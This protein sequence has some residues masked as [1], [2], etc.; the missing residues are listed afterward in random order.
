MT[1]Y[2][3]SAIRSDRPGMECPVLIVDDQIMVAEGLQR[4]LE[5]HFPG[6]KIVQSGEELLK[7]VAT[8][9]PD[10][11][12][13]DIGMPVL[14]GIEVTRFLRTISPG[15]KVIILTEHNRP[16]YAAGAVRAG[17]SGYVLKSCTF[18]ELMIAIRRVLKGDMYLTP[19]LRE[20]AGPAALNLRGHSVDNTLTSRQREV[21]VFVAEG[22]TAKEIANRLNFSVKTAV[23]H[24]TAIMDKLGVRTTAELTRYAFEHGLLVWSDTK[25]QTIPS[26]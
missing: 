12:L 6:V 16:E 5:D 22:C 19:S 26:G 14:N 9:K 2:A 11:V 8:S 20:Q 13:M 21:L 18:S 4:L 25:K 10:V 23:F 7:F 15:T 3:T 24:K 17:A 1:E